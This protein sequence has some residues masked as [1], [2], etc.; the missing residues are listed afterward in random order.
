MAEQ[1]EDVVWN[2][3]VDRET[4]RCR[5]MR[6]APYKG[7]LEVSNIA[8]GEVIFTHEV[9]LSYEALFGPDVGDVAHWQDLSIAA[10]DEKNLSEL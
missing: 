2:A 4:W 8:T 6:T 3:T 5:V 7:V 9:R 10:I 1:N